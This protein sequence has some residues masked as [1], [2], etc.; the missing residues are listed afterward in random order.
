MFKVIGINPNILRI[1]RQK[2]SG[3]FFL[4]FGWCIHPNPW[5]S[6]LFFKRFTMVNQH[7]ANFFPEIEHVNGNLR[8]F[9]NKFRYPTMEE[10]SPK[11]YEYSPIKWGYFMGNLRGLLCWASLWV[12]MFNFWGV[13]MNTPPKI[14][15]LNLKMMV[16]F[17]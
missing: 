14:N 8:I 15:S 13:M 17:R 3:C 4:W 5:R 11:Q 1:L 6:L 7:F 10:S 9:A 2:A 16:W 12:S